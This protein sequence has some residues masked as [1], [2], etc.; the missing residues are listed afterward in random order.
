METK[1]PCKKEGP[2]TYMRL[3]MTSMFTKVFLQNHTARG[4]QVVCSFPQL[5]HGHV[6]LE[7][8]HY[9]LLMTNNMEL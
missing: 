9:Q 1:K 5:T 4:I 3:N 6:F 7:N 2:L 8:K